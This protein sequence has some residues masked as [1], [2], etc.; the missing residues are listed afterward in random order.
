MELP[1]LSREGAL[2]FDEVKV[3][4]SIHWNAKTNKFIGQVLALKIC[5]RYMIYTKRESS[6]QIKRASYILVPMKRHNIK[7]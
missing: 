6:D 5:P 4:G 7:L 3:F 1:V 2:I